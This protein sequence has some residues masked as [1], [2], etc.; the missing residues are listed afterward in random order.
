M[1]PGRF[2]FFQA[3]R[4]LM[5]ILAGAANRWARFARPEREAVRF[6]R[7]TRWHFPPARFKSSTGTAMP[8]HCTVNFMGLTGPWVC[9]RIATPN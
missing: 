3:V 4:L 5:R 7:N 8:P 6:T 2:D 1:H 9:C